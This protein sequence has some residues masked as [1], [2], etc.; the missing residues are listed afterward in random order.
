M[1]GLDG[2]LRRCRAMPPDFDRSQYGL[3]PVHA[4]ELAGLVF[5]SFAARPPDFG[6]AAALLTPMATPQ[7]LDHAKVAHTADYEIAANWKL[8]WENN[9]ECYHLPGPARCHRPRNTT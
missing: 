2:T 8:V 6:P 5:V 7:G 1:D 3:L 4:T 9:R